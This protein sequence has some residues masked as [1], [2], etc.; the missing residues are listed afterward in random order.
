[1]LATPGFVLDRDRLSAARVVGSH[2]SRTW[3]LNQSRGEMVLESQKP[4]GANGEKHSGGQTK[5]LMRLSL[6]E[7]WWAL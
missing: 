7:C 4:S 2:L 1:M 5:G 6:L 3:Q